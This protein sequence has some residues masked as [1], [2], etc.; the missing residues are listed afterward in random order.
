[1]AYGLKYIAPYRTVDGLQKVVRFNKIG[2]TGPVTEWKTTLGGVHWDYGS[3]DS[4]FGKPIVPSQARIGL[5]FEEQYD[6]SEFVYDRKT[7]FAEIANEVTG[8]V[9]WSGWLEPWDAQHTY[10][11]FPYEVGLT[12][13]CGLAHLAK[14]KYSNPNSS[15]KK[16]GLQ[17]I[18]ECLAIIGS[19]LPLRTSTHMKENSFAEDRLF[20][21]RSFEINTA[22]YYN[23]NGEAM[24]C[25][26]IIAD[27][28]NK[29]NAELLQW[30]NR[31][32]VRSI[33]DHATGFD[34]TFYEYP[35]EGGTLPPTSPW[36]GIYIT[37]TDKALSLDGGT[38]SI[39]PPI[40]KYR[41]EVNLGTQAPYFENG[42]MVLW[43]EDGLIGWD[44]S[45]MDKGNPGWERHFLGEIGS[46]MS[47]LRINGK[48]PGPYE[49]KKKKKFWQVVVPILTGAVGA[50]LKNK[51]NDIEPA[52]YI[53]SSVGKVSKGDKTL[54]I[55]FDYETAANASD[56]LISIRLKNLLPNPAPGTENLWIFDTN[57]AENETGAK[58]DFC[59]IRIPATD[60]G[61][62]IYRGNIDASGNPNY[63][64]GTTANW[65]YVVTGV[66]PG[67]T[68][69]IGGV[70]GV[71][72][73]N[74]DIIVAR[75]ANAGGTQEAVGAYWNVIN[76]RNNTK[77]STF[78]ATLRLNR[79]TIVTSQ[80]AHLSSTIEVYVRFYK[81][82]DE[83]GR[84]GD[85]YQV[86]NLTGTLEGF[87]PS[88]ESGQYA[89]T[90]ERGGKTDE[91]AETIQLITGDYNPWFSGSLTK[92][93]SIENTKFWSRRSDPIEALSVYRAMMLDRLCLTTRPL[94]VFEGDIKLLPGESHLSY[95]HTL[96]FSDLGDMRMRIV[97]YSFE[98]YRRIAKITAIEVKYEEIPA[99]ELR[100]D[101]YIPGQGPL[102][103]VPGQGDGYYPTKSDS[104][105]GR[106]SAEDLPLTTEEISEAIEERSRLG[107][108]FENIDPLTYI[109]AEESTEVVN[110]ID[111]LSVLFIE[112]NEDQETEDMF[113]PETL[114]LS[115]VDKPTW[116]SQVTFDLL[117]VTATALAPKSGDFYLTLNAHDPESE[118]DIEFRVPILVE[119]SEEF[120]EAWPPIFDP[121]LPTL[122]FE[123]GKETT[124]GFLITDYMPEDL[125]YE[126]LSYRIMGKPE[127]VSDQSVVFGEV[128]VTGKPVKIETRYLTLEM[129]DAIG[130]IHVEE[131]TLACI[132]KTVL[133]HNLLDTGIDVPAILGPVPGFYG[134][135]TKFDLE[136]VVTGFHNR[137]ERTLIGGGPSGSSVNETVPLSVT[138]TNLGTYRLFPGTDGITGPAGQYTYT[139]R[140]YRG[141]RLVTE[142]IIFFTLYDDEF[143]TK[144]SAD[145]Y[146][147]TKDSLLGVIDPNGSSKF[148]NVKTFDVKNVIADLE[149]DKITLIVMKDSVQVYT[150]DYPQDPAVTDAEYDLFGGV[151]DEYGP[152]VYDLIAKIFLDDV[153]VYQRQSTFEIIKP[154]IVA[155]TG[156][157]LYTRRDNTVN[158]DALADL[159]LIN[160]EYDLPDNWTVKIPAEPAADYMEYVLFDRTSGPLIEIDIT[161]R[162]NIPQFISYTEDQEREDI[163]IFGLK[164]S[165]DIGNIHRTPSAFRVRAVYKTGGPNGEI[166][167][168]LQSDFGFRVPLE[169]ADYS[170]LR[171]ISINQGG[172]LAVTVID[173]DIP[174]SGR[175]YILPVYPE[176]WSAS[177][178]SFNGEMFD[179]VKLELSKDGI[180]LHSNALPDAVTIYTSDDPITEVESDLLAYIV[181]TIGIDGR[182]LNGPDGEDILIDDVGEYVVKA[183]YSLTGEL[184]GIQESSFTLTDENP[185]DLPVGDCCDNIDFESIFNEYFELKSTDD[186]PEGIENL[187]FNDL[188]VLGVT[189]S[190][191]SS[192]VNAPITE[193]HT[194]LGAFSDL[195][196]QIDDILTGG[197]GRYVSLNPILG[198]ASDSLG[199]FNLGSVINTSQFYVTNLIDGPFSNNGFASTVSRNG[200]SHFQT[201]GGETEED[202]FWWRRKSGGNTGSWF[203]GAS[204]SFVGL[205][206]MSYVNFPSYF[207]TAFSAKRTDDLL[208]GTVNK[209]FTEA[210]VRA[211]PLTGYDIGSNA[212]VLPT[213]SVLVA[214]GK[215]EAKINATGFAGTLNYYAKY[216]STGLGIGLMYDSGTRVGIGTASPAGRFHVSGAE[217][218]TGSNAALVL[219]NTSAAS[220]NQWSFMPAGPGFA[221][222]NGGLIIGDNVNYRISIATNGNFGV[223]LGTAA[224]A[225]S[226]HSGANIRAALSFISDR[227]TGVAPMIVSSTTRVTNFN[228]DYLDD[229][230]GTYYLARVNHTGIS[231]HTAGTGLTGTAYDGLAAQT[232]QVTYGTTAGTSVQGN[233]IRVLNGQTAFIWGNHALA[234]YGMASS[235]SG[236]VNYLSKFTATGTIG[237]SLWYDSGSRTGYGTS[238]PSARLHISGSGS[239]SGVDA[240][241]ALT[242]TTSSNSWTVFAGGPA[243][244][245]PNNSLVIG[246]NTNYRMVLSVDGNVGIGTGASAGIDRLEVSGGNIRVSSGRIIVGQPG[247]ISPFVIVSTT[248]NQNLNSDLLDD[249]HG[250]YYLDSV[251][252][253][254][255]R[256][257][258]WD[259]AYTISGNALTGNGT[260]GYI[261]KYTGTKTLAVSGLYDTG[262]RIGYG[263]SSPASKFHISGSGSDLGLTL[264]NTASSNSW[265]FYAGSSTTTIPNNS[266]SFGDNTN[267]RLLI[268]DNGNVGIGTG[269]TGAVERLE[270][271]G[272]NIRVN[273]RV[274]VTQATGVS[275]F[276][277][278]STTWNPNLNADL[279]DDQHGSYYLNSAN[280]TGTRATNW[281]SAYS[282]GNHASANYATQTQ[283]TTGLSGKADYF[284]TGMG[285]GILGSELFVGAG[286]GLVQDYDGLYVQFGNTSGTVAQGN[287]SRINNGQTAYGWGNHAGFGY[288]T[289]ITSSMISSALGF[290]PMANN[291]TITIN[292]GVQN[293]NDNA[294]FTTGTVRGTGSTGYLTQWNSGGAN[295]EN[296]IVRFTG[297]EININGS[298]GVESDSAFRADLHVHQNV[299]IGKSGY[300]GTIIIHDLVSAIIDGSAALEVRSTTKGF[301]MPRMTYAQRLAI[302]SPAV[303]LKVYQTDVGAGTS[304]I[305]EKLHIGSGVWTKNTVSID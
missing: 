287:D 6:L 302:S 157:E 185:E 275:P 173:T 155:T 147:T 32:V 50:N 121:P 199:A 89:T 237:N 236:T 77:K 100:Q 231:A 280:F 23:E 118:T 206:Y 260:S 184:V 76:I 249:Q 39:L 254:G 258:N 180:P 220:G 139:L 229:Q 286:A 125:V 16:T 221:A 295:I 135:P 15:F 163:L 234:G 247:G 251:N 218:G 127:W 279:L 36:P 267:Y 278:T 46:S 228:A 212:A 144:Y 259:S 282:W 129:T 241:I 62:L 66:P 153:Q 202:S 120:I 99:S 142:D 112:N 266:F 235:I 82:A 38:L 300:H 4:L 5:I 109:V 67:E 208:E 289:S 96:V 94:T 176:L 233:D 116:V 243:T 301:L 131:I 34:R 209:Y 115:L 126:H 132:K 271:S 274:I 24:Y 244:T 58:N 225:E 169:P 37:N 151:T 168:I 79:L 245:F 152:G 114:V 28:L 95:L 222:L 75:V 148:K 52:Q 182:T 226:I 303:G 281:D 213:D 128:S 192:G 304:P 291:K 65:A 60:W 239:G 19:E 214:F 25:D 138:E 276:V 44:F 256:A 69:K 124:D 48:S 18:Q 20:G 93:G 27:I 174:N 92:P 216:T 97:R 292:G 197:T 273:G 299:R 167:K 217:T 240:A 268:T 90:L 181:G 264:T 86:F 195:Q 194:V 73:E 158:F 252:F 78:E 285:I 119:E 9:E 102:N 136:S 88:A 13:S 101:S 51:Y 183:T 11:K 26:E 193:D 253:T 191:L 85:W 198:Y 146:D 104:S 175:S 215:L 277:I 111:Y 122:F 203:R 40:N 2:Y 284:T 246:D 110:L 149:H 293:L 72:V 84:P 31:W 188:L 263:T 64:S 29:L 21:L 178:R 232:W 156:L 170:G 57:A 296:S 200:S 43:N 250:A 166:L 186:L 105:N 201:V 22:R 248:W 117:E 177:A 81:I 83:G 257:T 134:L 161:L 165:T 63:P 230:H 288:L 12:A 261:S 283:L 54:K 140:S 265:A 70:N 204:R 45:H 42:N 17:I 47:A 107:P 298:L 269:A 290:T 141:A 130:R 205:N 164:D 297:S 14:K 305:G 80:Y 189:L 190:G 255:T 49:K 3:N 242:N 91:E 196:A 10:G 8:R 223:G 87:V 30:D 68:R 61:N 41:T 294:N 150:V 227:A 159:P 143:L 171:F 55:T 137:L 7:F 113:N 162:T 103:L 179:E 53:E 74:G 98:D 238:S 59:L 133:K 160:A 1:M 172:G 56:V 272:G 270:V 187:Y 154:E 210:R 211:T 145:L 35:F 106:L 262:T 207:N 33:V 71:P 219:Q 224:A 108:L 123:V